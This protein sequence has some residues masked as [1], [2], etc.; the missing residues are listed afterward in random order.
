MAFAQRDISKSE[1]NIYKS[2]LYKS[3]HS[4]T[5][6]SSTS[7]NGADETLASS[8]QS[9]KIRDIWRLLD[10]RNEDDDDSLLAT[11]TTTTTGQHQHKHH[12]LDSAIQVKSLMPP[13]RSNSS[14]AAATASSQRNKSKSPSTAQSARPSRPN[15]QTQKQQQQQSNKPK[16]RNYNIKN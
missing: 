15:E 1:P 14:T 10:E 6:A 9:E 7:N 13:Q 11:P 5:T 4:G 16:I 12:P 8:I 2:S 3:D